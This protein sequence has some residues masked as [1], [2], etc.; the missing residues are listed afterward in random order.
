MRKRL[1]LL[2]VGLLLCIMAVMALSAFQQARKAA[3][4]NTCLNNMKVLAMALMMYMDDYKGLPISDRWESSLEHYVGPVRCPSSRTG[5][6]YAIN[7][8]LYSVSSRKMNVK[9]VFN[10]AN[11]ITGK[12]GERT[13]QRGIDRASFEPDMVVF[14]E[15]EAGANAK[16]DLKDALK[17]A[18][19]RGICN[20]AFNDGHVIGERASDLADLRWKT[21]GASYA[22][23]EWLKYEPHITK[24]YRARISSTYLGDYE[25]I[26][27]P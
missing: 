6:G 24:A 15:M 3:N 17:G 13:I 26:C 2:L 4:R 25:E 18:R 23:V 14:F 10:D 27:Q 12:P 11:P 9:Q 8:N 20:V 1:V 19:H 7:T 21:R 16:G 22:I 5:S